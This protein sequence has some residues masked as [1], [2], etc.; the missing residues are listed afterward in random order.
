MRVEIVEAQGVL[1]QA[2][3]VAV[4]G[5]DR[6]GSWELPGPR[7]RLAIAGK[8]KPTAGNSRLFQLTRLEDAMNTLQSVVYPTTP[9]VPCQYPKM[10][11]S[12]DLGYGVALVAA[13]LLRLGLAGCLDELLNVSRCP[14]TF[15]S[16]FSSV[17]DLHLIFPLYIPFER[18]KPFCTHPRTFSWFSRMCGYQPLP[19]RIA[20]REGPIQPTS[21]ALRALR[22]GSVQ[23]RR[24]P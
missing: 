19:G 17:S 8:E 18:L 4:V 5:L 22:R 9:L 11:N 2:P 10:Q 3:C 16:R 6:G 23:P 15:A 1:P 7:D 24:P 14:R 21:I 20:P 13:F 12:Q